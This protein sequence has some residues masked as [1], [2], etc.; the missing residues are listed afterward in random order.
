VKLH[1]KSEGTCDSSSSREREK[2]WGK[3][4]PSHFLWYRG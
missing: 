4:A 3:S 2:A 1:Y